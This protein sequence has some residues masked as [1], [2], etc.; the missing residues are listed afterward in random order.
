[1]A[2]TNFGQLNFA[3]GELSPKV[4]GRTDLKIYANGCR[5]MQN[6]IAET[7]GPARFR[8]G[9]I[10]VHPT[11]GNNSGILIPFQFSD[12]QAYELEFTDGYM[13]VY[14]N[15][16][17]VLE[18]AKTITG[19]TQ[20]D[21]G[22][23]IATAHGYSNGEEVFI[24]GIVGMTELNG[25]FFLVNNVT[26][27][28]FELQDQD[29]VDIDTSAFTA[30]SSGGT[31]EKV[32][33][34]VVPYAEADLLQLK[35]NQNAD[36]MYITH[37]DYE[38]RKLTRTDHDAWTIAK[39]TRTNDP[40][41]QV[42]TAATQA[43][44]CQVAVTAHGLST[45]DQIH[46]EGVVGMTELNGLDYTITFVNANNFTLDGI[47]STAFGAYVS[48]GY[49]FQLG[50]MPRSVSFYEGR[51]GYGG[52]T[53][54]PESFWLSR[55]P[56]DTG[57]PR[58]DDFT[59]GTDADHAVIFTLAPVQG[60]VDSF[61]WLTGNTKYLLAGTFGGV[62]KITGSRDDE[63]IAPDSI[64]VK[65]VDDKGCADTVPIS[66]GG[67]ILYI[68]R[69]KLIIRSFE[70]DVLADNFVSV[71]RNLPAEHMTLSGI[72]QIAFQ[73]G[74]PDILWGTRT[75][76]ELIGLTFKSREDVS[77]WH[78]HLLGG[79]HNNDAGI[80]VTHGRVLSVGSLPRENNEDQVWVIVEREIDGVTRRF[81]EYFSDVV[82]F[83]PK[84]KFF[85]G[86]N[87]LI[88]DT[89][90]FLNLTYEKQKEYICVDSA[91]TFDGSA[92]GT[93]ASATITPGAL[94]GTGITFTAS[95]SV[96]T[97]A[98]V[99]N[100]IWRKYVDGTE[101]GRAEITAFVSATE[102]TCT[103]LKDFTKL[104]AI[105]AGEWFLT[106]SSISGLDHLEGETVVIV[107]DGRPHP[108]RTVA[109][110]AIAL[111]FEASVV[112]VGLKY[113]GI[114][115]TQNL[116]FGGLNG[117]A[118]A[119][120]RNIVDLNLRLLSSLGLKFGT[121]LYR[122]ESIINWVNT[123]I[124]SRPN[125]V[126]TG[127]KNLKNFDVWDSEKFVYIVQDLPLPASIQLID[128]EGETTNE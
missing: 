60:K 27:N 86:E 124:T 91:L 109:S 115:Q 37:P 81:V 65:P 62:T 15:Q 118:Q 40:F 6:F 11:R 104:T 42:I 48:G 110:G 39:F 107:T 56:E 7:Q 90:K 128:V 106:A 17:I 101:D 102:V 26:A 50:D 127:I 116:E 13:R 16:A 96:F 51:L 29:G 34:L 22:V 1:M 76:G 38:I 78:R 80:D 47:D 98:D 49:I 10:F 2:F 121:S 30:Y 88:T 41:T 122:L 31:A 53:I 123:N 24:L 75:D 97:A 25:K 19:V 21:P 63:P 33:E 66:Q 32:F 83:D 68:Q 8:S 69:G 113:V 73:T 84:E 99:G 82:T 125:P 35:Y 57:A 12:A 36:T 72:I 112:H 18:S 120:L 114:L 23:V 126:F 105:P 95:A 94:T 20:A 46:I 117:P 111:Q 4:S 9:S 100:E 85:T 54:R 108:D 70:F 119:K 3:S 44:P 59:T 58:Y 61:R 74:Q 103:I 55:G 92:R 28:T 14:R 67:I 5:R 87:N 79:T 52:T 71:D 64:T 89:N 43:N 45:G 93:A 77:G